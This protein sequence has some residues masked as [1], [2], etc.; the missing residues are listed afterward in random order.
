MITRFIGVYDADGSLVGEVSYV[1]GRALGRAH[2]ALCDI[3]HGALRERADWR[4]GV[5]TLDVPFVT[6]HRDDQP[7][8]VRALGAA[9]PVVVAEHDD[10]SLT[11]AATAD[12]LEACGASPSAL[13]QLL[14][15]ATP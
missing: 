3:T 1:V 5:R 15:R 14:R 7:A 13:V 11:V 6:Y 10:G 2:C 12:D 4:A 9:L 8:A